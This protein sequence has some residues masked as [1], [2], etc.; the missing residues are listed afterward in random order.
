VIVVKTEIPRVCAEC[1]H[2]NPDADFEALCLPGV[3]IKME[4]I[5][6]RPVILCK[7]HA[8]RMAKLITLAVG[9]MK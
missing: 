4:S 5:M 8:E 6:Q 2:K 3:V 9:R 7:K 1:F